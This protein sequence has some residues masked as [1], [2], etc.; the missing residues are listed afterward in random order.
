MPDDKFHNKLR[1][2]ICDLLNC[3]YPILQAGMG[4]V[5]R[6]ELVSA[7]S[8]AGAY[9]FLGMVRESPQRI[10]DEIQKVRQR[11]DRPFG[12]N[13]IPAA[14][15]T[16][17]LLQQID[18]CIEN[19]I[20]S[21][22]LFWDVDAGVI[23]RFREAGILVL[24]QIGST[25]DAIEAWRAGAQILIAQGY[26]AGGHVRGM[27]S[28]F[29]LLPEV[30]G[31]TPLPVVASGGIVDGKGML[32]AMMLGAQGVHC[33]TLFLATEESNAHDFH[34]RKIVESLSKDTVHT[35]LFHINW[36]RNAPVR[37]IHNSVTRGE[38]AGKETVIGY[39]KQRPIYLYSTDSPLKETR[40]ELE[41]MALYAGQGVSMINDIVP[42]ERR[43]QDLLQQVKSSLGAADQYPQRDPITVSS[44]PCF[45]SE[46]E[47]RFA[48]YFNEQQK[49]E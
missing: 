14:T 22:C 32:A 26:E 7:V 17:L 5:A 39:E 28:L 16:D 15:K 30:A 13:I 47:D 20:N 24:H 10:H 21:I 9:G 34:K 11:T 27:Q 42:A 29:T 8:N 23:T 18:V 38:Y 48:G 25:D 44:P 40:G 19:K 33:G 46:S 35:E 36:P 41:A 2:P 31:A 1:T 3:D 6:A 49:K 37:V 12:V 43:V 45:L 4:G